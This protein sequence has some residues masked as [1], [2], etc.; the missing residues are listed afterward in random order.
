MKR[1]SRIFFVMMILVGTSLQVFAKDDDRNQILKVYNWAD[2]IDESLI[3]EFE[4]WY[5]ESDILGKELIRLKILAYYDDHAEVYYVTSTKE[6]DTEIGDV[7]SFRKEN[8]KWIC[9]GYPHTIWSKHGNADEYIWPY[10]R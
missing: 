2:Y 5:K 7:V 8:G 4:E 1:F 3:T 10:G 9:D 6:F